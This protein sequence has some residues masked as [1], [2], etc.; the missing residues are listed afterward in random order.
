MRGLP[1]MASEHAAHG[2]AAAAATARCGR[3]VRGRRVGDDGVAL[4]EIAVEDLGVGAVGEARVDR[5]RRRCVAVEHPNGARVVGL[6]AIFAAAR[7]ALAA[8]ATLAM[9]G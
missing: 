2:S 8:R 9:R 5:Y 1:T 3:T 6:V 4:V 7:C